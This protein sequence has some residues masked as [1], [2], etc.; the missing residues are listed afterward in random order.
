METKTCLDFLKTEMVVT[1]AAVMKVSLMAGAAEA[2]VLNTEATAKDTALVANSAAERQARANV[3]AATAST[4]VRLAAWVV[5]KVGVPG[6]AVK[7]AVRVADAACS[8]P[9]T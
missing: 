7:A 9:V 2:I 6:D 5:A 4:Q 3:V 8:A 1:A